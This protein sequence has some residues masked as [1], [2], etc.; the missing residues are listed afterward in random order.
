MKKPCWPSRKWKFTSNLNFWR[1][2][3]SFYFTYW[4]KYIQMSLLPFVQAKDPRYGRRIAKNREILQKPGKLVVCWLLCHLL[5]HHSSALWWVIGNTGSWIKTKSLL[6]FSSQIAVHEKKAHDNWVRM[7]FLFWCQRFVFDFTSVPLMQLTKFSLPAHCPLGWESSGWR[8][9]RSSQPET[10]VSTEKTLSIA[11][12]MCW[13]LLGGEAQNVQ[14][15]FKLLILT[16]V[17]LFWWL[18]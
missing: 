1:L 14:C 13:E 10:E 3:F 16:T 5:L 8:E 12:W 15:I 18:K 6:F 7:F 11:L 17:K 2:W 4:G 9:K